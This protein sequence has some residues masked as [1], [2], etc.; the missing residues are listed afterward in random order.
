MASIAHSAILVGFLFVGR[1]ICLR[2]TSTTT[3]TIPWTGI[4]V[5]STTI[6]PCTGPATVVIETPFQTPACSSTPLPVRPAPCETLPD[7]QADGLNIDYYSNPVNGYGSGNLPPSYYITQGLSPL[8]S[9]LTNITF[10]PQD[11]PPE[12]TAGWTRDTN[13]GIIVNANNFTLVYYGFYL[14]PSTGLFTICSSSDNE[15]DVFFGQGNAFSCDNGKPSA[16][17]TPLGVSKGGFYVDPIN[18]TDVYLTQGRYYPVRN[19]IGN[20]N[21]PSA[22]NFTIW[23]PG[24][25]W[26]DRTNNFAGDVYPLSCGWFSLF[27]AQ[28]NSTRI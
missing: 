11:M 8:A 16:N 13:G 19:V 4:S 28:S 26:E 23:E 2:P 22:F 6:T 18:C 25:P 5:T 7:C 24:V 9:S 14:A 3:T 17:A 21:G 27:K 12:N 1:V 20:Y 10:F 15:N